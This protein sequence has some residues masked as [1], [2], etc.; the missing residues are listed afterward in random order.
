MEKTRGESRSPLSTAAPSKG[1]KAL[2]V[3]AQDIEKQWGKTHTARV[4]GEG[5][6]GRGEREKGK[7]PSDVTPHEEIA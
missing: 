3:E 4:S 2:Y 7:G 6:E 1:S 5:K